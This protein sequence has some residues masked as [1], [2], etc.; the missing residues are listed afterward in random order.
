MALK[1]TMNKMRGLLGELCHDLEK[2]ERGNK[3]A[4][5]RVR[6]GSIKFEKTAK[7]YRKES[8]AAEKKG[9]MKKSPAKTKAKAKV[10]AKP[11]KK[12][13]SS[14]TAKKGGMRAKKR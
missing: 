11:A 12:A 1:D 6:T 4:S 13:K 7:L 10:K 8:V 9:G 14:S 3:A 5:Q 2:S